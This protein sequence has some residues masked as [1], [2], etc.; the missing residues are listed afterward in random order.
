MS[1]KGDK[2]ISVVDQVIAKDEEWRGLVT[3]IDQL[4]AE[5]NSKA[6]EIGNLMGQGKKEEAQKLIKETSENKEK[7]KELEDQLRMVSEERD[8]L[9][10]RIPN[11][12]DPTVP[13]GSTPEDNQVFK[14]EGS[15]LDKEWRRPHWE[16]AGE[17]KLD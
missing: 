16:I 7:I 4:R 2:D 14:T 15:K 11:V 10:Y 1:N 3:R 5:S 13:V 17:K 6:K 12:P 8:E 9:L